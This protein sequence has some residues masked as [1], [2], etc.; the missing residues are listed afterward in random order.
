[1]EEKMKNKILVFC[2]V[3]LFLLT[4]L[5]AISI[6]GTKI[7]KESGNRNNLTFFDENDAEVPIWDVGHSWTY[8]VTINGGI[9]KHVTLNNI[10]MSNLKFTV[11]E[12]HNET[13]NVSFSSSV[14]GSGTVKLE[15]ISISGQL[16]QTE[17][18]GTLIVNKSKLT[19]NATKDL[20]VD[21]YVKPPIIPKI[22]FDAEGD[23]FPS[24]GTPLLNFPINN[25]DS[26]FVDDIP[27]ELD[28]TINVQILSDPIEAEGIV[29]VEGHFAECHEWDIVNVPAGEYDALKISSSLGD[30]HLVWYS[31]AAG[32]FV[33]MRGRDIP[34]NWGYSGEYDIDVV[35]KSTNFYVDSD[36]PS[37]PTTI[38]GP[39]EVV[40]GF[41]ELYTIGGSIDP[42]DHMIRYFVDWGDGKITAS[43][44]VPSGENVTFSKYWTKKGQYSVK[45][46]ARDKYG[47]Q[48]GW[49][50][51]ISITVS[52]DPPL[53]PDP[54]EGPLKGKIRQPHTY[55]ATSFDPDGH[56]IRFKFSWGDG[57]SSY[58]G[59]VNSG[60]TGSA[61]HSWRN[62]GNYLI[63]VK[64]YD[65]WGEESGWSDPLSV[66]M[67]RSRAMNRPFLNFL[68]NFL[69]NH[70]NLFPIL[71]L[72]MQRL[73]L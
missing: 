16:Q 19:I 59:Y 37:T 63:K 28:M 46:K 21:G 3:S 52:N 44:F 14:T 43:D 30:E 17:I 11:E 36:P 42:D 27:I 73:G 12:V 25:Y 51:P 57:S 54:P 69:E 10:R 9:P 61:T 40:A 33:K 50:D 6:T 22:H 4:S 64:A 70:P 56:R 49:S 32:N 35:L 29:H 41:P 26:W 67:P 31:V 38:S 1:V 5:P 2:I 68:Q 53:T 20:I 58:S 45:A 72:L 48:S 18:E 34:L 8:D 71:Q 15:F 23:V 47:A 39:T 66:T 24:Y 13:Y 60:E 65:E 55:Y 7:I 62:K